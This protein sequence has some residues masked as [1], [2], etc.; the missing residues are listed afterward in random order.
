MMSRVQK[1]VVAGFA[2]TVAVSVLEVANLYMGPWAVSFPRLLSVM[3]QT[4]DLMAVGWIAHFV[5]G[6]LILGPLFAILCPRLPTDTAESKGILFAVGAFVVLGLTIAPMAGVVGE[7]P[8]GLFFMQA[9]FGTFAWMIATHAV[10]GVVLG[11]V[12][13][14]LVGR[15]KEGHDMIHGHHSHRHGP[16]HA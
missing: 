10:F 7:R 3:L 13:G 8:V 5:A 2:A 12:Y 15:S 9:G 4:P 1:G 14:R 16:Y 11:N 6:T